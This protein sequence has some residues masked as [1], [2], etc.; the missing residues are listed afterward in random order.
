M[1]GW[2]E[3]RDGKPGTEESKERGQRERRATNG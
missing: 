1:E 3:G 2:G